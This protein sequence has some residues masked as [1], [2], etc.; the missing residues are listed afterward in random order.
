[1][2]LM[3]CLFP[4]RAMGSPCEIQLYFDD[5]RPWSVDLRHPR[6][7]HVLLTSVNFYAGAVASNGD[8]ERCIDVKGRRY[9]HVLNPAG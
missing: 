4:F 5:D 6:K 8:Y 1:M 2:S 3:L 7:S 9:S